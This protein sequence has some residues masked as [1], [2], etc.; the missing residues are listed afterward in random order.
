M[1]RNDD[2]SLKR[3][4]YL[5]GN[6]RVVDWIWLRED[7]VANYMSGRDTIGALLVRNASADEAELYDEAY[8][9]GYDVAMIYESINNSNGVT[10]RIE[11]SED[12]IATKAG[13]FDSH[14]MFECATCGVNKDFES[15]VAVIETGPWFLA[16]LKEDVLWFNCYNCGS[17]G[18][19]IAGIEVDG[20]P[21]E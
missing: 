2:L 6:I 17:M 18:A 1:R 5:E 4:E 7:E 13:D 10:Y 15:D 9:D 21:D 12:K 20:T 8:N 14:K 16:T 11:V 3:F 19:E